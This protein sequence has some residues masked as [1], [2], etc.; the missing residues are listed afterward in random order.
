MIRR[1]IGSFGTV[2]SIISLAFIQ[3]M[4]MAIKVV[5]MLAGFVCAA[6]L[7]WGDIKAN[8]RNEK[9]CSSNAE[10][11]N[12][13]KSLVKTQGKVC[14]MSR[15]LSWVDAEVEAC[16]K[17]KKNSIKIFVEKETDLTRRLQECGVIVRYYGFLHFEPK[18]RFTVIGYNR[19]NPQVAIA[20]TK[21]S[22]RRSSH[23]KHTIYETSG[24]DCVQDRWLTSLAVDMITLCDLVSREGTDIA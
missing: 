6:A 18:T 9:V 13:M 7:L 4:P 3:G 5:I 8:Q 16:I 10:V 11:K 15:D 22:I 14:M 17:E 20:S 21:Y 19:E 24:N 1:I 12:A 2:A 23:F